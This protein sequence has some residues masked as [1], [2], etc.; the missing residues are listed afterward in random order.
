MRAHVSKYSD[1]P[2]GSL[3]SKWHKEYKGMFDAQILLL[4]PL[5]LF[6]S[7]KPVNRSIK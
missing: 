3:L 6:L 5:A 2:D 4:A 1:A 7:R